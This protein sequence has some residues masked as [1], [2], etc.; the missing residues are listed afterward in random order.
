[1]I[2][3]DFCTR[4]SIYLYLLDSKGHAE[5]LGCVCVFV[6][7]F[8]HVC[9]CACVCVC[10]YKT[11]TA[12]KALMMCAQ[13]TSIKKITKVSPISIQCISSQFFLGW[14]VYPIQLGRISYVENVSPRQIFLPLKSTNHQIKFHSNFC[15]HSIVQ[16]YVCIVY[17]ICK[18]MH[19]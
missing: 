4:S 17:I 5:G 14:T 9:V 7:V 11:Y 12:I 13:F 10:V 16:R 19:A 15:I 1:M 3:C 18:T 8:V 2:S 6:C